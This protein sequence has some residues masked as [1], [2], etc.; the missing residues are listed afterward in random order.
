MKKIHLFFIEKI[1]YIFLLLLGRKMVV[2]GYCLCG[3]CRDK[4][5][6]HWYRGYFTSSVRE[7]TS[8]SMGRDVPLGTVVIIEGIANTFKVEDRLNMDESNPLYVYF[9]KHADAVR[10]G[11]Q[12]RRVV[13]CKGNK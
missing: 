13:L 10:F 5:K 2:K 4:F 7:G 11:T 12:T 9:H 6:G 1:L 3:T 8:V